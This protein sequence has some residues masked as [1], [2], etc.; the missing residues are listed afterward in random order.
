MCEESLPLTV[1]GAAPVLDQSI[2]TVFPFSPAQVELRWNRHSPKG[3]DQRPGVKRGKVVCGSEA[4]PS[5]G[6]GRE[7]EKYGRSA[8]NE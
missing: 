1:A 8:P 2:R 4:Q 6:K 3:T 5:T 7:I